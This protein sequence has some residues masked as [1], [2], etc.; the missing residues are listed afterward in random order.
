MDIAHRAIEEAGGPNLLTTIKI[1]IT[2]MQGCLNNYK[3][4]TNK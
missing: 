3:H 4:F 2:V 1:C